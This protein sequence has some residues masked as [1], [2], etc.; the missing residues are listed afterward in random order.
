MTIETMMEET[1]IA[2]KRQV[3]KLLAAF[4]DW[5]LITKV[6]E[7]RYQGRG[8]PTPEYHLTCVYGVPQDIEKTLSGVPLSVLQVSP[9]TSE[10][11]MKRDE[12]READNLGVL[13]PEPQ[14]EPNPQPEPTRADGTALG[15]EMQEKVRTVVELAVAL[16]LENWPPTQPPGQGLMKKKQN[17]YQLT[18]LRGVDKYPAG[19]E[20]D[21]ATWCVNEQRGLAHHSEL[22]ADLNP[23]YCHNCNS[24]GF[25]LPKLVETE[26]P[27]AGIY[28]LPDPNPDPCDVC[29]PDNVT[30]LDTHKRVNEP[31]PGN[32]YLP[33]GTAQ[34]YAQSLVG[35]LSRHMKGD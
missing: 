12:Q 25:M 23:N 26:I 22:L 27:N 15:G 4:Q 28:M 20:R 7:I 10:N 33:S 30:Q 24:T 31:E 2:S 19:T 21:L 18:A 5:G 32:T 9:G 6:G 3:Q 11:S 14:P 16:D 8:R 35:Q 17:E 13:E 1:G 29:N 34:A